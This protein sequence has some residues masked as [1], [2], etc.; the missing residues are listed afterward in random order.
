VQINPVW[1]YGPFRPEQVTSP[2][3]PDWFLGWVEGALRLFPSLEI[4]AFGFEIPNVF[5]PA[6][7]VPGLTF[8]LLYAWPFLEAWVTKD[9]APHHVLDRPR[10]RPVRTALGAATLSFYA[11]LFFAASN[12]LIAKWLAVPVDTVTTIF[13]AVLFVLPPVVAFVTYRI[14]RGLRATGSPLVSRGPLPTALSGT[15]STRAKSARRS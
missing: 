13:V 12:D 5:Y 9:T 14:M 1:L 15:T 10:D 11:V 7:L 8:M 4:R 3:Q 2:A 6:V